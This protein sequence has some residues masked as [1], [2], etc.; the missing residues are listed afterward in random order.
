MGACPTLLAH[1]HLGSVYPV[2]GVH[3]ITHELANYSLPSVS[4]GTALLARSRG[5]TRISS[6]QRTSSYALKEVVSLPKDTHL[7]VGQNRATYRP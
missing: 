7:I 6:L 5:S 2:V 1:L 3:L 4:T